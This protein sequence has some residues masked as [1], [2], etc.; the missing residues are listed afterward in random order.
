M[1]DNNKEPCFASEMNAALDPYGQFIDIMI[2]ANWEAWHGKPAGLRCLL[3]GRVVT[4]YQSR[5]KNRWVRH[6]PGEGGDGSSAAKKAAA[7]ETFLHERCKF[8]VRDRLRAAGA[9]ADAEQ[10]L[11]NRRPDVLA[12]RDGRRLA[13]EIQ[14]SPLKFELAR[15]RTAD[16]LRGGADQVLWLTRDYSWVEK[17]P[18]LGVRNFDPARDG[19]STDSGFL[20]MTP[21]RGLRVVDRPVDQALRAL[22]DGE[23]AWAYRDSKKAG[24]ATVT[25]WAQ[26]TKQQADEIERL[27]R[28]LKESTDKRVKLGETV[29]KQSRLIDALKS[30]LGRAEATFASQ[31]EVIDAGARQ[32]EDDV[33]TIE[34]AR[35]VIKKVVGQRD[36]QTA[37]VGAVEAEF[38]GAREAHQQAV[39]SLAWRSN[40]LKALSVVCLML[41]LLALVASC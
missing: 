13:V 31:R 40:L 17:L 7:A 1:G 30:D 3:C 29:G 38:K 12:D 39:A 8:W 35:A 25:D 14:W 11:G 15:E 5:A 34:A 37:A 18:A 27:R 24:W 33:A 20:A 19:Y 26:H 28:D 23:I 9:T 2:D 6:L 41:A 36:R 32:H 16:L 4:A 21:S 22:L 10:Q